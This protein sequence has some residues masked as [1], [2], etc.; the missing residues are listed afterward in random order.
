MPSPSRSA[1]V[2]IAYYHDRSTI[3]VFDTELKALRYA[4]ENSM[5]VKFVEWGNEVIR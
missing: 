2:W 5:A 3:V 4:V 1:G